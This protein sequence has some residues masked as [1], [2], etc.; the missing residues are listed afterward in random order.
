[1]NRKIVM[2]L[3][4]LGL[5]LSAAYG[6][7]SKYQQ[8]ECNRL[9][10]EG[11]NAERQQWYGDAVT[12]LTHYFSQSACRTQ[13]DIAA[14][15]S[16]IQA[17]SF[18]PSPTSDTALQKLALARI[19]ANLQK[20]P[21]FLLTEAKAALAVEDWTRVLQLVAHVAEPEATLMAVAAQVR[22]KQWD[23]LRAYLNPQRLKPLSPFRQSLLHH[24]LKK[25]PVS[26][27]AS[28]LPIEMQHFAQNLLTDTPITAHLLHKIRLQFS[29]DD[30]NLLI[31]LLAASGRDW[32]IPIVLGPAERALPNSLLRRLARYYWRRGQMGPI[33]KLMHRPGIFQTDGDIA[34]IICMAQK[35]IGQRCQPPFNKAV[36]K[37]RYGDYAASHWGR[38]LNLAS[39]K[40]MDNTALIDQ[41]TAMKD[42]VKTDP[43]AAQLLVNAYDAIGETSLAQLHAKRAE[44]LGGG[45]LKRVDIRQSSMCKADKKCLKAA[46]LDKSFDALIWKES[47][48]AGIALSSGQI[49][50]L[51]QN[52]PKNAILWRLAKAREEASKE[53][54]EGAAKTLL[55]LQPVLRWAP[56]TVP[57][58]L[59][60]AYAYGYFQ[61]KTAALSH[62]AAA[63]AAD[64]DASVA[65][66]RLS[67]K[68]FDAD[69]GI[70]GS[71]L[72]D[73]WIT[74][75]Q[76]EL[77]D[78]KATS[79]SARSLLL[80]RLAI[81]AALAEKRQDHMLLVSAY[82]QLLKINPNHHIALNNLAVVLMKQGQDLSEARDLARKAV[83]LSPHSV[84]Y[85][86]TLSAINANIH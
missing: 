10:E 65:V 45:P 39:M 7:F 27:D 26:T 16:L 38:L 72:V 80:D 8:H 51:H 48:E 11:L 24:M 63:V 17:T 71:D 28:M 57:A 15:K 64:P 52:S 9:L 84:D 83:A 43:V 47:I 31:T 69:Q 54:D 30:L 6:T 73:W 59:L 4:L 62:L 46:L 18:V 70:T 77:R 60:V 49:E 61:D 1:M 2:A 66:L 41:L 35:S 12:H 68:M 78:R 81:L 86:D 67:L 14:L 55:I 50:T 42:L 79:Q 36:F 74:L 22:L 13:R 23:A 33:V 3:I 76:L 75:T 29:D 34:L 32:A 58:H 19:G 37:R 25:S 82:R 40:N 5:A 56:D 85:A 53:T 20:D 44:A 21:Q